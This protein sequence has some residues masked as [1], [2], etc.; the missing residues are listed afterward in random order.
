[1]TDIKNEAGE[2]IVV[3]GGDFLGSVIFAGTNGADTLTGTSAAETFVGGQGNDVMIGNGG[4]DAFQGGEGNDRLVISD[5]A[6]RNIDGGHGTD[7]LALNGAGINFDLT[8]VLPARMESIE[9]FDITGSGNN[10]LTLDYRDI[11]EFSGGSDDSFSFAASNN[12]FVID[13]NAGDSLTLAAA[14]SS[15]GSWSQVGR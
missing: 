3:F 14:S 7:T 15:I 12:T 9:R 10:S 8:S 13:G 5:L 11:F 4:A 1:M 6:F 2:A